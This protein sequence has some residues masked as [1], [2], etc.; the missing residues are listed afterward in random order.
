MHMKLENIKHLAPMLPGQLPHT[1]THDL[2][3]HWLCPLSH[4]PNPRK[5]IPSLSKGGLIPMP[6]VPHST[7]WLFPLCSSVLGLLDLGNAGNSP[8]G[9]K[10]E[11]CLLP[12][13]GQLPREFH[14]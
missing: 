1:W 7:P 6:S 5:I 8:K 14:F 11:E 2:Q 13:A 10:V 3:G 12:S 4:L 9:P